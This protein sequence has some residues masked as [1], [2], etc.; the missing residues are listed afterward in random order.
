M[1]RN[2]RT[3]HLI[4]N[5]WLILHIGYDYT[6]R[7]IDARRGITARLCDAFNPYQ[8]ITAIRNR[9]FDHGVIESREFHVPTI[10]IGNITVGGTGKT[11]HTE[12]LVRLLKEKFH[13]AVL[14]RGYGRKSKGYILADESTKTSLEGVFAAGDVRTK[15]LR[16]VVTAAADGAV[17]IAVHMEVRRQCCLHIVGKA[18]HN[19]V[20]VVAHTF[21]SFDS[22]FAVGIDGASEA[23]HQHLADPAHF[24]RRRCDTKEVAN[25]VPNAGDPAGHLIP[26]PRG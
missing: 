13:T 15:A 22:V 9:L 12:Y 16:Q 10:C 6:K 24:F 5:Y 18:V 1:K 17:D 8:W 26:Q 2:A 23:V 7:M 3:E 20:D 14:S 4:L 25:A 19:I 21:R 11:P